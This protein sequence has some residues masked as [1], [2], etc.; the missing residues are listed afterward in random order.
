MCSG[1]TVYNCKQFKKVLNIKGRQPKEIESHKTS[2]YLRSLQLI[3]LYRDILEVAIRVRSHTNLSLP[4][5]LFNLY[6]VIVSN[7]TI[8]MSNWTEIIN[9]NKIS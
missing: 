4:K 8:K 7:V 5:I 1:L 3:S 9:L 6:V 2:Q